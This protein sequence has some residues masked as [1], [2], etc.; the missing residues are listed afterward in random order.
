MNGC[1]LK[2]NG[3]EEIPEGNTLCY[4]SEF[5]Q[6]VCKCRMAVKECYGSV[7]DIVLVVTAQ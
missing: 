2:N 5:E 1:V 3:C 6:Y 7:T 4:V